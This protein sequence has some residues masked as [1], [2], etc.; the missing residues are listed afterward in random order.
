MFNIYIVGKPQL[1]VEYDDKIVIRTTELPTITI[2]P[3]AKKN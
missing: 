1:Q 3:K 2:T